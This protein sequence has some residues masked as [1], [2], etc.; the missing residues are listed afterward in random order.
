M[1]KHV[2]GYIIIFIHFVGIPHLDSRVK[3]SPVY[4]TTSRR[5]LPSSFSRESARQRIR[6]PKRHLR[7]PSIP[8]LIYN[9]Q[10]KKGET[11]VGVL[12]YKTPR[13]YFNDV[14]KDRVLI[15]IGCWFRR[16]GSGSFLL[17]TRVCVCVQNILYSTRVHQDLI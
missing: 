11:R 12:L 16:F 8:R 10:K 4:L 6:W 3:R 1:S 5:P 2:Y 13:A 15:Y 7:S 17:Y 14:G 9:I